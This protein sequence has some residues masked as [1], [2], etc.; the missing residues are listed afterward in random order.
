M[1]QGLK[2]CR[3]LAARDSS[4]CFVGAPGS[5]AAAGGIERP[6]GND[7]G[8]ASQETGRRRSPTRTRIE[9]DGLAFG[10]QLVS[11]SSISSAPGERV[12][13]RPH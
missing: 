4:A 8:Q 6:A 11:L 5:A 3:R 13:P 12:R 9:G 1:A 2:D 7:S 10:R